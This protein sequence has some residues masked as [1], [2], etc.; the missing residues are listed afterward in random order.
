M[1]GVGTFADITERKLVAD[2]LRESEASYRELADSITDV[3]FAMDKD[4]RYTYWNKASENLTG[5]L[6]QDAIGKSLHELFPDTPGIRKAEAVYL[7]VVR[8]QQP[9]TFESVYQAGDKHA[10]FEISAY[11]SAR[12]ISVFTKDITARKRAEEALHFTRF[13]VDS[14]ADTMVCVARDARFI[15]VNDTFCR[16]S[17]YSREELLSKTVPDIDPN[18]S[19]E[20]WPGFWEKLKQSG[21]LTFESYHRTK[22]GQVH[23]VEI[24]ATWFEYDGKEYHSGFARDI[25]ARKRAETELHIALEKYRVLFESFPLGISVTDAAGNL[26]E[27]NRES[28]RLLGVP[29]D[30]HTQRKYD[31]PEWRIVRPDGTP[32]PPDEYASVRALREKRLVENVEMGIVKGGGEIT[33]ISVTAAPIPLEGY[34]VAIAYGDITERKRAE[35]AL[36]DTEQRYRSLFENMLDGFAYCKMLFDQDRPVDFVYL[37][38]NRAFE[39]LTGLKGVVGKKV[40]E[41]IPGIRNAN[42]ELFEIYGRVT[43]T[44]KP[45]RFETYLESLDIWLSISV[46]STGKEYFVAVFDNI[47]GRKRAEEEQARLFQEVRRA[48]EQLQALSRRLVEVQEIER[49]FIARELHDEVGQVLTGLKMLLET[50]SHLPADTLRSRLSNAQSLVEQLMEQVQGMSLDLRPTML[51]DLGLLPALLWLTKRFADQTGV[52]V[53]L[54]HSGLDRRFAPEIETAAYR[55]TQEALTNVARHAS[56]KEATARLWATQDTLHV[57]VEDRGQGFREAALAAPASIGLSGMRERAVALGGNLII[58]STPGVGT[59]VTLE[60]PLSGS[61]ERIM[62]ERRE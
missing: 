40:T 8:T 26:I 17:G 3:F 51:D 1:G 4:L 49:R 14:A 22:E 54:E 32:M 9:Q 7:D 61:L 37:E 2:A 27:V 30:E 13:S 19:A 10:I 44:G 25:T 24:T 28:E 42:P 50:S 31:G 18:F 5:I 11:P 23:P 62:K 53:H 41:V 43:L 60:V 55:V 58:E 59:C 33:W 36:R 57:Q 15:D 20:T 45:E 47:T 38:V 35:E 34:G 39:T 29:R 48:R 12:G 56:V 46:Y 6:A 52:R 21:S 16:L